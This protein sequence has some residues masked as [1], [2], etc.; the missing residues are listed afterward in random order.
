MKVQEN[1][2]TSHE[3][4]PYAFDGLSSWKP[5][6]KAEGLSQEPEDPKLLTGESLPSEVASILSSPNKMSKFDHAELEATVMKF[7]TRQWLNRLNLMLHKVTSL[8]DAIAMIK[9]GNGFLE[10]LLLQ[11]Y[12]LRTVDYMYKLC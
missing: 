8:K 1:I 6:G 4:S 7:V 12:V 10:A 11:Q 9:T 2:Y 5:V 3:H